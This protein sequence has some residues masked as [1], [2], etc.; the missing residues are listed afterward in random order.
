LS[1][2]C[3]AN[4]LRR[5]PAGCAG[6]CFK[7]LLKQHVASHADTALVAVF[8]RLMDIERR[9]KKRIATNTTKFVL[10]FCCR[11]KVWEMENPV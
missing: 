8:H 5:Y 2:I 1:A 7:K 4:D 6:L 11:I 10:N 9:G 3:L